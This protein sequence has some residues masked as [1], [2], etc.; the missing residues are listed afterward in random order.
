M[1]DS[2]GHTP[3]F[4][5]EIDYTIPEILHLLSTGANPNISTK[6][7]ETLL[8]YAAAYT[9]CGSVDL[10]LRRSPYAVINSRDNTE[11]IPL[12][13]NAP[14]GRVGVFM[15]LENT[16]TNTGLVNI[17]GA[18]WLVLERWLRIWHQCHGTCTRL[19]LACTKITLLSWLPRAV[20]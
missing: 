12:Y 13:N 1:Q 5:S 2:N 11:N 9:R 3:L 18:G 20:T 17:V 10:S 7:G 6:A 19:V 4:L 16:G 14:S 8:H 15:P